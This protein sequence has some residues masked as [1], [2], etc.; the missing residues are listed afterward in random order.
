MDSPFYF[1][2]T[3]YWSDGDERAHFEWLD[4][5]SAVKEVRGEGVRVFLRIDPRAVDS[6]V[7]RE[8]EAIYRRY[9]GDLEQ[10]SSLRTQIEK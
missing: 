10:L 5:I 7:L 3:V 9:D 8:L 1:E 4:R 6:S 2:S